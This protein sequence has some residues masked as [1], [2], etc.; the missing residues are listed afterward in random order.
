MKYEDMNVIISNLTGEKK[1]IEAK[2]LEQN[3]TIIEL[4]KNYYK[5]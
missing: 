1:L 2:Y 3:H 5:I 4:H